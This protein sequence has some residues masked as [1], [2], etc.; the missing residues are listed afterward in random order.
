ME[1]FALVLVSLYYIR[2]LKFQ[3]V[4][5]KK[6]PKYRGDQ[7]PTYQ[8]DSLK[9]ETNKELF[10]KATSSADKVVFSPHINVWKSQTFLMDGVETGNFLL[11]FAQQLRHKNA[12][13]P[14]IYFT[15]LDATGISPT[16]IPNQSAKAKER[17]MGPFQSPN[18]KS[19]KD[20]TRRVMLLLGVC[21]I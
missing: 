11:D 17:N 8:I 3:S 6:L 16:L 13:F 9:K 15:L 21:A 5:K 1:Q 19:C 7:N 10:A 4:T 12:D 18:I 2:S 14:D 20:L